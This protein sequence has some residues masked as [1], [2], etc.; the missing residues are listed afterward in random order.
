MEEDKILSVRR[1]ATEKK[2]VYSL[3]NYIEFCIVN[4]AVYNIY[5]Y[6]VYGV[7][8]IVNRPTAVDAFQYLPLRMYVATNK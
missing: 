4:L 1:E 2:G 5:M 6:G 3:D 8:I 7:F